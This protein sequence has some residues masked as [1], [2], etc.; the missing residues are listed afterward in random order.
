LNGRCKKDALDRAEDICELCGHQFCAL[1]LLFPRGHR[2]P[3]T[4]KTCALEHS[5][6][7]GGS[8]HQS[9]SKREY[10]KRKKQ[11]LA[12]LEEVADERPPIEYFELTDPSGFD[13][14]SELDRRSAVVEEESTIDI[15]AA[16]D[17]PAD[18]PPKLD[19]PPQPAPAARVLAAEAAGHALSGMAPVDTSVNPLAVGG[20][21]TPTPPTS[22]ASSSAAELLA[23]LKA[24]EPIQSQ[25]TAEPVG[26]DTDPF[27]ASASEPA[28][29]EPAPESLTPPAALQPP[30]V[31]TPQ[32]SAP[33][34]PEPTPSAEQSAPRPKTE[35]WSPPTP[36]PR[37]SNLTSMGGE[38][39]AVEAAAVEP[40][41]QPSMESPFDAVNPRDASPFDTPAHIDPSDDDESPK[42]RKADV[43]EAGQWIPPSLRGMTS[44]GE[45]V[46]LPKRRS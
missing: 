45:R 20:S 27:A 36:P 37:G 26:L 35:P 33:T 43:D 1:C 17:P 41:P 28:T 3:P 6:L 31:P 22:E 7:R 25:F 38:S 11:L 46:A 40:E 4:C 2:N 5:G 12:E 9:I 14:S 24:D 8:K 32:T 10:K 19:E 13:Q 23:R 44:A 42:R 18:T 15:V 34:A 30:A 29:P 21:P 16:I 39:T